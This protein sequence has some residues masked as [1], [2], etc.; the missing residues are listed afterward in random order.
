MNQSDAI[1]HAVRP[2]LVAYGVV[3][4]VLGWLALQLAFGDGG[5]SASSSGAVRTLAQQPF[6]LVL[7]WLVALG[8]LL[9]VLWQ[10]LE[11]AVGHRSLDGGERLRKRLTSLGKA[12]VYGYIGVSALTIATGTGSS[13]GGTDSMTAQVMGLPGG[14]ALVGLVGA[15]IIGIGGFLVWKGLTEKF[16]EDL[17]G[18]GRRGDSGRVYIWLGKVGYA[19][20]GIALGVVGALFG[21]AAVTHEAKRSGGLDQ[22]LQEVLD[23]PF[24]PYL[25]AAMAAGIAAFGAFCFVHARHLSR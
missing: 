6:G 4:L 15:V 9:L 8:M 11:A 20:K 12:V 17:T 10:L 19:A 14:Q 7:V 16:R 13:G 5:G 21:Y 18:Q 24:G 1:D 2:G 22:A 25:L 3:H 23:Q